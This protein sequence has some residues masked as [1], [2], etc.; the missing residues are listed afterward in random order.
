MKT[1][2]KQMKDSVRALEVV[3]ERKHEIS[4][5]PQVSIVLPTRNAA[6]TLEACLRSVSSQRYEHLE[7]IVADNYSQDA[8]RVI[9]EK[10]GAR[11]HICG[12]PPPFNDFF[13][14]PLQRKT[15]GELARGV[16]LFFIDADMELEAGL[17]EECVMKCQSADAVAIPEVSFGQGFWTACRIVER[18][19]YFDQR[20]HDPN[21][22][23][24]RF[25]RKTTYKSVGGWK[26]E[27]GSFDDWDLTARLRRGGFAIVRSKKRIFHNE[28]RLTLR[29]IVMKQYQQGKA[30]GALEYLLTSG[31]ST[32]AVL[33]QVTPFRM[34]VL[35][36]KLCFV[37]KN[38]SHTLG[39]LVL[40]VM[41]ALAFALGLIASRFGR[42]VPSRSGGLEAG[43]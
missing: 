34:L 30:S 41:D 19:C 39:I 3:E 15:G 7:V 26:A 11:V 2:Q 33:D 35:L 29:R 14:A 37:T 17:I 8:T 9:A 42:P 10:Y 32:V 21:I 24:C 40:K 27:A 28:G 38:L 1:S 13:T 12:P 20:I 31:A 22:Q 4:S 23:A 16:F 43:D 36:K 6:T 5:Q 18:M 25:I